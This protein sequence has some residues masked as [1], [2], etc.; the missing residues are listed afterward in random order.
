MTDRCLQASQKLLYSLCLV[1]SQFNLE[2]TRYLY[3]N[4]ELDDMDQIKLLL[5]GSRHFARIKGISLAHIMDYGEANAALRVILPLAPKLES[6][7][8]VYLPLSK[9]TVK[10]VQEESKQL[11][12]VLPRLRGHLPALFDEGGHVGRAFAWTLQLSITNGV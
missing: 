9:D 8:S 7:T 5:R 12:H 10:M 1:D 11:K 4:I 3:E 2:F 6:L